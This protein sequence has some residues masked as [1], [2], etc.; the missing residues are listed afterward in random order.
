MISLL[1][2]AIII[3]L[4][5]PISL[6]AQ[7]E[8][9]LQTGH[10]ADIKKVD[11]HPTQNFCLSLDVKNILVVWD[12][13]L[14]SQYG[15]ISLGGEANDVAFFNDSILVV[16][17]NDG[18]E[19]WNFKRE[20]LVGRNELSSP[21][22]ELFRTHEGVY[23]LNENVYKIGGFDGYFSKIYGE[24]RL[25]NIALSESGKYLSG[26]V[27]EED[28]LINLHTGIKLGEWSA[29]SYCT[30]ISEKNSV[31]VRCSK[32]AVLDA[33][34]LDENQ[35]SKRY[36]L[37][38]V[39][40]SQ[41]YNVVCFKDNYMIMGDDRD[42]VSVFD[43]SKGNYEKQ[44]KNHGG[45]ITAMDADL[46]KDILVIGGENGTLNLYNLNSTESI[47][48][49]Q[50]I[51]S[52]I[53]AIS[54]KDESKL[55]LGYADGVIKEWN[56]ITHEVS[57]KRIQKSFLDKVRNVN[58]AITGI[59]IDNGTAVKTYNRDF[60]TSKE[61]YKRYS[62]TI[63]SESDELELEK[64]DV[65]AKFAGDLKELSSGKYLLQST[66][67]E[68]ALNEGVKIIEYSVH[69]SKNYLLASVSDGF[70]YWIDANTGE[71]KLKMVSPTDYTFF[72]ITS[73][74]YYYGSKSAMSYVGARLN[75]QLI[76]FEQI[77]L[78]YNRPDK[79]LQNLPF[80]DEEYLSLL[81]EAYNKR[82]SKLGLDAKSSIRI[83]QLPSLT[84]NIESLPFKTEQKELELNIKG[85]SEGTK[86][87]FGH[88]L[89]NGVP[90]FGRNGVSLNDLGEWTGKIS[91]SKGDNKL[92]MYVENE[93]GLKSVRQ[94]K[95][96]YCDIEAKPELYLLCIG[97][98]EF[99]DANFN[100]KYAAK[101]AHD[102]SEQFKKNKNYNAIHSLE[103]TGKNVSSTSIEEAIMELEKAKVD[104]VIIVFF[105]GHGVLDANLDY[106]LSTYDMD[107]DHPEYGGVLFTEL[108]DHLSTLGCRNKV[109]LID[110][111][112]SGEIDK[113][114]IV[115]TNLEQEDVELVEFR[116]GTSSIGLIGGTS[117]FEL[118]KN[119]FVDLRQNSGVITIS[120]AGGAEYAMEGSLWNNGVFTYCLIDGIQSMKADLN[121]DKEI[122]TSE[123]QQYLFK[124]VP[125]IT[126]GKQTP[127][128]R[129][130]ILDQKIRLW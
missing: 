70:L 21:V 123:L 128:S 8:L 2:I 43:L 67:T 125:R 61:I 108:E 62:W 117:V 77:D 119:I 104:D 38:N 110:A 72:Y 16:A 47:G 9:V 90:V 95:N 53:T 112:H 17:K 64:I 105:A 44:F 36:V 92:Q 106:Y 28:V 87:S 130:E 23:F 24:E 83:E 22:N 12:L 18:L 49:L 68:I 65:R 89:I 127:T 75:E 48:S 10:N 88:V 26:T 34:D 99:I 120:S 51:S 31:F 69:P 20:E 52:M 94:E 40:K 56:L 97:S 129:V 59:G 63:T 126:N 109:L 76:G 82:L 84:S 121:G 30:T 103:L 11:I 81:H 35:A 116:S 46:I 27:N 60:P 33:Y 19:F 14:Q 79:V 55:M 32:G 45:A 122:Y 71:L 96:I 41:R 86:I 3:F 29:D 1:R 100:L 50:G 124:E 85:V 5:L 98:G 4:L 80:F 42:V 78:L 101:D 57:T 37:T 66:G 91:L 111:C 6:F 113:E 114:E 115:A 54:F 118:S 107:F 39:R 15:S 13:D 102:I 74:N 7:F 58:Y 93:R 73:E 25:E